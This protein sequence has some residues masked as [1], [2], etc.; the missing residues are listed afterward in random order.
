MSRIQTRRRYPDSFFEKGYRHRRDRLTRAEIR[1][2]KPGVPY[3]FKLPN[4]AALMSA[5]ATANYLRAAEHIP[6]VY[7]T[8]SADMKISIVIQTKE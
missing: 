7:K 4:G 5:R 8:R 2:L 6:I 3:T 1:S